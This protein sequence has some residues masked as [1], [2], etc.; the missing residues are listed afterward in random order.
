MNS[1]FDTFCTSNTLAVKD[2]KFSFIDLFAGIGGL[3]KGFDSI[4]GKCVFT[5]EWDKY[6]QATYKENYLC[7]HEIAG[8]RS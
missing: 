3:R 7:N 6:C 2:S 1:E 4:G 5:S 8:D